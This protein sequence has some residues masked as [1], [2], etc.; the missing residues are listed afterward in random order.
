M[1][2]I[3]LTIIGCEG[4]MGKQLIRSAK[5]NKNF[6]LEKGETSI[7]ALGMGASSLVFMGFATI[8]DIEDVTNKKVVYHLDLAKRHV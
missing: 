4:R 6:K 8:F 2:K 5:I 1:K 3:N 7:V